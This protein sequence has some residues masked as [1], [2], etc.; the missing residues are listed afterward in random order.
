MGAHPFAR[1]ELL[2][3]QAGQRLPRLM[4]WQC[5]DCTRYWG[6]CHKHCPLC[7]L[8]LA[9]RMGLRRSIAV[10]AARTLILEF[11]GSHASVQPL[12][13]GRSMCVRF[14]DGRMWETLRRC[15]CPGCRVPAGQFEDGVLIRI[16]CKYGHGRHYSIFSIP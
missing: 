2:W 10:F 16:A 15:R 8:R 9:A 3:V 7:R 11:I 12:P 5:R 13:K 14:K 6:F 4:A 1:A